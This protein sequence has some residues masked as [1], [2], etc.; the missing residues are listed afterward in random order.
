M[1]QKEKHQKM[2]EKRERREERRK[3]RERLGDE[4]AI[5]QLTRVQ[6][7]FLRKSFFVYLRLISMQG[8]V[9]SY[10]AGSIFS[11]SYSRLHP[12]WFPVLLRVHVYWMRPLCYQM[13]RRLFRMKR[14]M[15]L[16]ATLSVVQLPK[17]CF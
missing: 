3:E 2:K 15:S 8:S 7:N 16:R 17:C 11:H 4:V 13:M 5:D 6:L 12:S 9:F 1:W 14:W 10:L